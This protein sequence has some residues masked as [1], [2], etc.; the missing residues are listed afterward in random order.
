MEWTNA[1]T[2]NASAEY[3][4]SDFDG[5]SVMAIQ[6]AQHIPVPIHSIRTASSLR[7]RERLANVVTVAR[8]I[9]EY[10]IPL[11]PTALIQLLKAG[12]YLSCMADSL[13]DAYPELGLA[14]VPFARPILRFPAGALIHRSLERHAP[15]RLL[16]ELVHM[17]AERLRRH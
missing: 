12:P 4:S 6:S 3:I 5:V 10:P 1:T 2:A 17:N 13:I 15:A 9:F 16:H 14:V 7:A 8:Y 11:G